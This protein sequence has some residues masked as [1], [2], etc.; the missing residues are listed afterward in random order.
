MISNSSEEELLGGI[1]SQIPTGILTTDDQLK[2]IY[3]NEPFLCL[4][5][6]S[7][8]EVADHDVCTLLPLAPSVNQSLQKLLKGKID[9]VEATYNLSSAGRL[10]V[11]EMVATRMEH[12]NDLPNGILI[13]FN[14][15]SEFKEMEQQLI[16]SSKMAAIG[17]MAA[18]F[19]HEMRNPLTGIYLAIE[20]L[21]IKSGSDGSI[22]ETISDVEVTAKKIEEIVTRITDFAKRQVI[23]FSKNSI[24]DLVDNSL[25]FTSG[26]LNKYNVTTSVRVESD[27]PSIYLDGAQ[28]I[29]VFINLIKN[30]CKAMEIEEGKTL[31]IIIDRRRDGVRIR[32]IDKGKGMDEEEMRQ[33]F[34]PFYSNFSEGTGLGLAMVQRIV[35]LH[36]GRVLVESESHKGSTFTV[37]L[38]LQI[39]SR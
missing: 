1:L 25:E 3:F 24:E 19:A 29:Q 15:L 2:V 21:K 33:V 16:Q 27:L 34:R 5:L 18:M 8:E 12:K 35:E 22:L 11:V 10:L 28:L 30:A 20:V 37:E 4:H 23:S 9:K 38:P 14:D 39:K 36:Q 7:K 6:L 26:Y 17:E 32:F 13:V 31:E